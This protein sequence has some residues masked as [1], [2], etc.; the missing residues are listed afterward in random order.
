MKK[1]GAYCF[2]YGGDAFWI[3]LYQFG[4][5]FDLKNGAVCRLICSCTVTCEC[6]LQGTISHA[7]RLILFNLNLTFYIP[8]YIPAFFHLGVSFW[9]WINSL[10]SNL[11]IRILEKLWLLILSSCYSQGFWAYFCW[12]CRTCYLFRSDQI[13]FSFFFSFLNT[14]VIT[15]VILSI[16]CFVYRLF[17]R[18]HSG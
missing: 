18:A 11:P 14:I 17:E 7:A 15:A 10:Q 8:F 16:Y 4:V 5:Y 9:V 13:A 3:W 6:P 12:N 2:S 1:K